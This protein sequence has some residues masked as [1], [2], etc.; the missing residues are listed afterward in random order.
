MQ[1]VKLGLIPKVLQA[2]PGVIAKHS[3]M[4]PHQKKYILFILF[5]GVLHRLSGDNAVPPSDSGHQDSGLV[6]RTKGVILSDSE[7][8]SYPGTCTV[9][10][11]LQTNIW[12][13]SGPLGL[14]MEMLRNK[15]GL[16]QTRQGRCCHLCAIS[17]VPI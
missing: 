10:T 9:L 6:H 11:G 16:V 17:L 4:S 13:H 2:L 15:V 7:G 3:W 14:N 5:P 8:R 12:Q 1:A